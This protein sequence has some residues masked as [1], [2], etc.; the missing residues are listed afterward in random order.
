MARSAFSSLVLAAL[1][2]TIVGAQTVY[3]PKNPQVFFDGRNADAASTATTSAT[4]AASFTPAA[5]QTT[6]LNRPALPNPMPALTFPA[7]LYSGGMANMSIPQKGDFMGFSIEMSVATQMLGKNSSNIY[8]PFLNLLANVVARAGSIQIRVGGNTQEN[9]V[10]KDSLPNNTILSKDKD[11]LFN[12][13]GTPP[14]DYTPDLFYM[15]GNIS[16]FVNAYWYLGIPFFNHTPFSLELAESGQQILGDRLLALQAGNE[17]DL[18]AAPPR[19][20]RPTGYA[21][22]DY[23]GEIGDLVNQAASDSAILK[24]NDVWLVPSVSA[25]GESEWVID[26]VLATGILD[27]YGT[28]IHAVTVE[29]YPNNNCVAIYGGGTPVVPQDVL[30]NYL[31][32]AGTVAVYS[33][34]ANAAN[35]AVA[36]GKPMMLFETNT[37]SCSGFVGVSDAFAAALWGIDWSMTLAAGNFSGALYHF[38]GQSASYNP[39]TPPQTNQ[40]AFRQWTVGPIYYSTLFLAETMGPSNKSQIVDLYTNNNNPSTPAWAVYEDGTPTK[41][42]LINYLDDPTG[43]STINVQ[44]QVGGGTTGQAAASPSQVRVKLLTAESTVQ[45]GNYSWA[46]QSFGAWFESDGRLQGEMQADTVQ[47]S[48]NVCTVSVPAPGAAL[49]FLTDDAYN[50]VTPDKSDIQTFPTTYVTATVNTAIINTTELAVSNGH[51]DIGAMRLTTSPNSRNKNGAGSL[52]SS[53]GAIAGAV[54]GLALLLS[55]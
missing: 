2:A 1:S 34:Y 16:N 26:N 30:P 45:K 8:V 21:P 54:L 20:H 5:Y 33:E 7:Q 29:R 51:G 24:Q 28:Q 53:V 23:F 32:H 31:S 14:I 9:A 55:A 39:F 11:N 10:L 15:M 13:T 6:T 49:V 22:A 4:A 41:V 43:A 17:P 47:C 36:H 3:M 12:P 19:T 42:V 27:S 48:N 35:T 37:A 50:A 40:T 46:G 52:E 44:I 38:G 25:T 18:Y